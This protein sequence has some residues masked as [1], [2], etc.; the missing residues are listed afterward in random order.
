MDIRK[1]RYEALQRLCAER[2]AAVKE[3]G[4]FKVRERPNFDHNKP[5]TW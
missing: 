3:A 1:L 2:F 5:E 4:L